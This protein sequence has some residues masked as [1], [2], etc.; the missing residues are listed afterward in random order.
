MKSVGLVPGLIAAGI[1]MVGVGNASARQPI[2][3][4]CESVSCAVWLSRWTA[5]TFV[6]LTRSDCAPL[7][8]YTSNVAVSPDARL[9]VAAES[10]VGDAGGEAC[11]M[12]VPFR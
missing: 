10:Q 1:L 5:S 7:G 4:P 11:A 3:V 8:V 9:A 2:G 6:P 12:R